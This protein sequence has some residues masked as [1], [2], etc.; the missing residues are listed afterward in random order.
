MSSVAVWLL[1]VALCQA[2]QEIPAFRSEVNLVNVAA[3]VRSTNGKLLQDLNRG[4]FEVLE[5][6]VPQTIQFFARNTEL[7]LSLG[8][9]VDVS[10]SQ[11]KFLKRHD[12]DIDIF[13]QEVL[14]PS[15]RAFAVC[16]G[17]HLRLVSD[18]TGSA[19]VILEGLKQFAKGDR[20][21]PEIGPEEER[22]LG[23]A[24]YDA[25]YFSIEEKLQKAGERRRFS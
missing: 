25:L 4:D 16:F 5:D 20:H 8:L 11:E 15:D 23:T 7:P 1:L 19:S 2:G 14:R 18:A 22:D 17:N 6:G 12:H 10:G 13:L 21:F 9:I 3:I 24:F